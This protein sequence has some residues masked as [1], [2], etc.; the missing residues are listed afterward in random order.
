MMH[1]RGG[2][3]RTGREPR[4]R[5]EEE[6]ERHLE[7]SNL[8]VPGDSVLIATSGGIDSMVLLTLLVQLREGWQLELRAAHFDHQIRPESAEEAEWVAE[9]CAR[10][11]V[12]TEI[13]RATTELRGQDAA[14]RA[15]YEFLEE[16]ATRFDTDLI[17]TGHHADDQAETILF[18]LIR[19][20]GIRGLTGIPPRRGKIVRPLLPF[21]RTEIAQY[22][23]EV[24]VG[25]IEDPSN[26][27]PSYARNRLRIEVIPLLEEIAPGAS[28]ALVRLGGHARTEQEVL[29]SLLTELEEE[30]VIDRGSEID[31]QNTILLAR[32]RLLSYDPR[33]RTLLVRRIVRKFGSLPGV[34]ATT[35]LLDFIESG[36]S[37][38][39]ITITGGVRVVREFDHFR[40]SRVRDTKGTGGGET[41]LQIPGPESGAGVAVLDGDRRLHFNWSTRTRELEDD[42]GEPVNSAAFDPAALRFPLVI[43]GWRP[44]DRI[45]LHYGTK[46]LKKLFAEHRIGRDDRKRIPILAEEGGRVLWVVGIARAAIAEPEPGDL[47]L[48][49]TCTANES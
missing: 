46:K 1:Q 11:G 31:G 22:A 34:G 49:V 17:A 35:E 19:G 6:F 21:W 29:E 48:L 26:E 33:V 8:I 47:Q 42:V 38:G 27:I 15:R 13:G 28:R 9:E 7:D 14:R 2:S 3:D 43:R 41:T 4:P 45:Q 24:G 36:R 44:G 12:P 39:E 5:L 20:T 18:R 10:W 16:T 30:I 25:H 23:D 32:D 37:G 40:L